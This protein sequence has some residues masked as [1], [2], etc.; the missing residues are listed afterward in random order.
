ML[1][2]V[3]LTHL[4]NIVWW[5]GTVPLHWA[6]KMVVPLFSRRGTE[7]CFNYRG[8]HSSP[9]LGKSIQEC[10]E[11]NFVDSQTFSE[12]TLWFLSALHFPQGAWGSLLNQ[13]MCFVDLESI[14]PCPLWHSVGGA[15]RLCCLGTSIKG[16]PVFV[17]SQETGVE[18]LTAEVARASVL[19]AS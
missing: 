3:W 9:S 5:S 16:G 14:R 15:P 10:G 11:E 2:V 19:D 8:S 13:S 1:W 7:G 12:V 17:W 4:C 18:L 6:T